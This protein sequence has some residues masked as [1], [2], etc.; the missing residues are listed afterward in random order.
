MTHVLRKKEI[1][2]QRQILLEGRQCEEDNHP[3]AKER[4]LEQAL[5]S[6]PVG[7]VNTADTMISDFWPP[8]LGDN[9]FLLFKPPVFGT[10]L[11]SYVMVLTWYWLGRI[12]E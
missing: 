6:Q 10:L 9:E 11:Q 3:Q 8:E 7:R 4:S 2:T 1:W 12:M 5:L